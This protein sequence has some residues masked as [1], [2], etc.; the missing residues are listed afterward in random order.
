VEEKYLKVQVGIRE[1]DVL[2]NAIDRYS[3]DPLWPADRTPNVPTVRIAF[4]RL[5]RAEI[6]ALNN[7][8][9]VDSPTHALFHNP[10]LKFV[11]SVLREP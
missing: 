4:Y 9:L 7:R 10:L 2:I 6:H 8:L 3:R 5:A 1:E 11:P